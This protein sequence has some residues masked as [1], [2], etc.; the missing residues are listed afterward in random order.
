MAKIVL[1]AA[2]AAVALAGGSLKAPEQSVLL[3][4][5]QVAEINGKA[6]TWTADYNLVKGMTKENARAKLGTYLRPSKYPEANWGALIENFQA[7]TSFDARVQWPD[8]V[9][10]IRD[11]QH[12]GSCWAFGATEALSDRF[13][14][15]GKKVLLSPQYLVSCDDFNDGCEGGYLDFAWNFLEIDG[16]PSDECVSYKSGDG[17]SGEC[18]DN[19][20]DGSEIKLYRAVNTNSFTDPS[21]IQLEVMTN[22]PIEVAFTVY[23]DFMSYAGG[24]YKHT[25][26][27]VLG[28]HAVKLVGW[29]QENGVDYWICANSWNTKWGENGYFRIAWG[30]VGI[31]DEGIAGVPDI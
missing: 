8:C 6:Q 28:G 11:Q 27:S 22:G 30:Q 13:C 4:E 24:V 2:L 10:Y 1:I 5:E 21:S 9:N 25:Y 31:E 12:C 17:N 19:C 14:I 20:D 15:K 18:P 29:G 7:P 23:E 16:I 26:G 3:T